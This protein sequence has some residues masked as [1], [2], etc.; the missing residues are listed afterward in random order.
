VQPCDGSAEYRRARHGGCGGG[1][2]VGGQEECEAVAH[3]ALTRHGVLVRRGTRVRRGAAG[4]RGRGRVHVPIA[5]QVQS[6]DGP[7]VKGESPD[8][9]GEIAGAA[10]D[11]VAP[12]GLS[13]VPG[14]KVLIPVQWPAEFTPVIPVFVERVDDISFAVA[15]VAEFEEIFFGEATGYVILGLN[16]ALYVAFLRTD[17]IHYV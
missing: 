8:V 16:G 15:P 6:D 5:S 2:D 10:G 17:E 1:K 9:L 12:I 14:E 11:G 7:G 4:G 3:P 13:T